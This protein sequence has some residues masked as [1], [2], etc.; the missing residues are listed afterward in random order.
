M[1]DKN[2]AR[3][4]YSIL[5]IIGAAIAV[6]WI[7][8]SH[9]SPEEKRI[10]EYYHASFYKHYVEKNHLPPAQAEYYAKHYAHMYAEYFASPDYRR[11]LEFALPAASKEAMQYPSGPVAEMHVSRTGVDAVKYF[12]GYRA[13][14]YRD[15]GGKM[16]IGYGHLI[17]QGE[18]LSNLDGSEAEKLLMQDI[19]L[20]EAVIKRDVTVELSQRQFDALVSLVFNIG[21]THFN[22]STMLKYINNNKMDLAEA[23][24]DRWIMVGDREAAGLKSRRSYERQ[25]FV[26]G[27]RT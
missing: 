4:F 25:L 19:G 5:A 11:W 27:R 7:Y 17:R 13:T 10:Y 6:A 23:E 18:V 3:I 12:E 15:I 14:P 16:T 24:F 26:S 1:A 8:F 22:E 21:S 2:S 9:E 20:A